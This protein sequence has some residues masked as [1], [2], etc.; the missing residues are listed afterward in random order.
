MITINDLQKAIEELIRNCVKVSGQFDLFGKSQVVSPVGDKDSGI[1]IL[2]K[3]EVMV[4]TIAS[5]R[6]KEGI[7][8]QNK[9]EYG[10]T[11]GYITELPRIPYLINFGIELNSRNN[12]EM[13][14]MLYGF[15]SGI[16]DHGILSIEDCAIDYNMEFLSN[17]KVRENEDSY[18]AVFVMSVQ[19]DIDQKGKLGKVGPISTVQVDQTD[20]DD[21][22]TFN[23]I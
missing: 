12:D 14:E 5:F 16:P 19:L 4:R 22:E 11:N 2:P 9:Y 10:T 21:Q 18:L 23:S 7:H 17:Q 13:N 1:D 20:L 3:I 15:L 8:A 6:Q